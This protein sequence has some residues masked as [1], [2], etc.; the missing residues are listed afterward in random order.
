MVG[1]IERGHHGAGCGS[2]RERGERINRKLIGVTKGW[3][4]RRRVGLY[5][6]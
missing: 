3:P 4:V 5:C 1:R 2:G 6:R